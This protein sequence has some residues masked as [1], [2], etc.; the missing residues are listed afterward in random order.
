MM[1][2]ILESFLK[3][4]ATKN[5][6]QTSQKQVRHF[7]YIIELMTVFLFLVR[8]YSRRDMYCTYNSVLV[9]TLDLYHNRYTEIVVCSHTIYR[10]LHCLL[11]G[12]YLELSARRWARWTAAPSSGEWPT[13][14]RR[15][16][17][18]RTSSTLN[19]ERT[20]RI[21]RYLGIRYFTFYLIFFVTH[22]HYLFSILSRH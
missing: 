10:L 1:K 3:D 13:S 8:S 12:R 22:I 20:F 17:S 16:R 5:N 21:E 14:T 4:I 6:L 11:L 7:M 2:L 15:A 19:Q 18:R 9:A